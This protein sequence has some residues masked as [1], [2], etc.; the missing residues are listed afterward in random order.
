[1]KNDS[2]SL[3]RS[4]RHL[5]TILRHALDDAVRLHHLWHNVCLDVVVPRQPK[6]HLV[7]KA[8]TIEQTR[9]LLAAAKDDELEALYVLALTTGMRQGELLALTWNDLDFTTG[10]L[11]VRRSLHRTR[12]TGTW[13]RNSRRSPAVAVFS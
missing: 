5:H 2:S 3:S 12:Q 13:H 9:Q 1:M 7:A 4:I 6:G 10:K 11:Q 8:L